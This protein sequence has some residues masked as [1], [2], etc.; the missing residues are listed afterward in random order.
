MGPGDWSVGT[1]SGS[2]GSGSGFFVP[3][4]FGRGLNV[5]RGFK[6]SSGR[7]LGIGNERIYMSATATLMNAAQICAGNEPPVTSMPR[8]GRQSWRSEQYSI[9]GT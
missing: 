6:I 8:T 2:L 4:G 3:D 5:G 7:S 9:N 1:G